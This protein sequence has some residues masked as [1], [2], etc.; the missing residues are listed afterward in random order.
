MIFGGFSYS[1]SR[2]QLYGTD[3]RKRGEMDIQSLRILKAV[4]ETGSF[5]AAAKKMN[6]AQSHISTQIQYLEEEIGAPLFTRHNRGVS[7]CPAGEL[8]LQYANE[9]TRI[10]EEA[11]LAISKSNV[12]SGKVRLAVMQTLAHTLL[13]D[14]LSRYHKK[15]PMVELEIPTGTCDQNIW[16]VLNHEADLSIAANTGERKD[17]HSTPLMQEHLVLLSSD[18]G[19]KIPTVEEMQDRT[20]LVF[21]EGCAYRKRLHLWL[22]SEN[23]L[24]KAQI[25]FESLSGI[26]ASACAGLG[27]TLLPKNVAE[28]YIRDHLLYACEIPEQFRMLPLFLIH[29]NDQYLSPAMKAMSKMILQSLSSGMQ[30]R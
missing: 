26:L 8:F 17:I 21:S 15:Y 9:M 4:A 22:Q 5:S 3:I 20:V 28:R 25:V 14:V 27:V 24:P 1:N 30:A 6:F 7:I 19:L 12:P 11:S 10:M 13:P 2:Y 16:A 29:R 18:P 23:I